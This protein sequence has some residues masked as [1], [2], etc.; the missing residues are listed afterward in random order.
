[1]AFQ[2]EWHSRSVISLVAH[3]IF[4][5]LEKMSSSV[6]NKL[7]KSPYKRLIL[8]RRE[9]QVCG[10]LFPKESGILHYY[11]FPQGMCHTKRIVGHT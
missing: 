10:F 11:R 4:V 7:H 2:Y 3:F 8:A 6:N 9:F 1:M 5:K